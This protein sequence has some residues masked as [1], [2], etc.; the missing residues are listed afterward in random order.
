MAERGPSFAELVLAPN[1]GPMTLEGTNTWVLRAPGSSSVVVVDP[2]PDD[3]AH[4]EAVAARGDVALVLLTH[5][6]LD[7]AAGMPA[8]HAITGA[9]VLA[10]EP[11]LCRDADPLRDGLTLDL[12]GLS[13]RVL[14]TPGHSGDS[15]TFVVSDGEARSGAPRGDLPVLH[16]AST[17]V[18]TGDT[19]LGRGTTVVA[20]PDGRLAD[21]LATL[22]RLG[23]LGALTV[24][25]GHG[26]V[27]PDL[28]ALAGEYLAHRVERLEQVRAALAAGAESAD[29]VVEAVYPD[30]D[31]A[32]RFAA[33]M[34]VRAQL[35]YLTLPP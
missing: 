13:V 4:L 24:L 27:R 16:D 25:P 2:G 6:H 33:L 15:A 31:P 18:L 17:A 20:H 35:D 7:H 32:I 5:G 29:D 26:P 3:T 22:H 8:F 14:V 12:A 28:A 34:S 9:P 11:T 1:P 30:V 19:I 23:A 10:V 21:Y